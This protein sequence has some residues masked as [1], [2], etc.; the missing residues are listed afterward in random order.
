[1]DKKVQLIYRRKKANNLSERQKRRRR[2]MQIKTAKMSII[3]GN[4]NNDHLSEDHIN[5]TCNEYAVAISKN[6]KSETITNIAVNE[7]LLEASLNPRI[8]LT[9]M[10]NTLTITIIILHHLIQI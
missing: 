3:N 6:N 2:Q 10:I 1:M 9:I 7:Y 5:Q 4:S 8:Q